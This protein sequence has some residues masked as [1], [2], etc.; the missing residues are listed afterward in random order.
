MPIS[1]L[2]TK[3]IPG[4]YS[5]V[6]NNCAH[7]NNASNDRCCYD[8]AVKICQGTN[9]CDSDWSNIAIDTCNQV[10]GEVFQRQHPPCVNPYP[11]VIQK[12]WKP[13]QNLSLYPSGT[14]H[15]NI[16]G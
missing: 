15:Q 13:W 11:P 16:I 2:N 3:Y 10:T 12:N 9:K 8:Q 7:F 14:F 5:E 6:K 1:G 4:I